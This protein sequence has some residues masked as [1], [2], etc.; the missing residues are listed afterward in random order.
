M[1]AC[2]NQS[3]NVEVY[4]L[5]VG[6]WDDSENDM[7]DWDAMAMRSPSERVHA[8]VQHPAKVSLSSSVKLMVR[9]GNS[10]FAN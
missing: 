10:C 2:E 6:G 1:T 3:L 7:Y 5:V 9:A 4:I 8:I